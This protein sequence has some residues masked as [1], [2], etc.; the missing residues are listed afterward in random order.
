MCRCTVRVTPTGVVVL[1]APN[2]TAHSQCRSDV[3]VYSGRLSERSKFRQVLGRVVAV[4]R[5][6]S[7]RMGSVACRIYVAFGLTLIEIGGHIRHQTIGE[8]N[9]CH[10]VLGCVSLHGSRHDGW[11]CCVC[12]V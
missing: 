12:H 5:F 6:T 4:A 10:Q 7:L 2:A 11:Q 3:R 9:Q 8:I 1:F